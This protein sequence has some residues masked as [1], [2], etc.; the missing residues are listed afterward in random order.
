MVEEEDGKGEAGTG[1]L[2]LGIRSAFCAHGRGRRLFR[3]WSRAW[4]PRVGPAWETAFHRLAEVSIGIGVALIFTVI[5][6]E[7]ED[8]PMAEKL[9]DSPRK[10]NG[11]QGRL[12][13]FASSAAPAT[14]DERSWTGCFAASRADF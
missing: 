12:N 8:T 3:C 4:V 14:A 5:W 1:R 2:G 6:P 10:T 11:D 9:N 7:R 13:E